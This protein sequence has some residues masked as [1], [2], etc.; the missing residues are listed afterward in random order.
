M[1]VSFT[2]T[3]GQN[4]QFGDELIG[5]KAV[6]RGCGSTFVIPP[7][8]PGTSDLP[9]FELIPDGA[10]APPVG[11]P[12]GSHEPA[13]VRAEA[14]PAPVAAK[15]R[16][17]LAARPFERPQENA[18]TYPCPNSECDA[19]MES[20]PEDIG[21]QEK[22]PSC[23]CR[24]IVPE[25]EPPSRKTLVTGLCVGG[26]TLVAAGV[27]LAAVFLGPHRGEGPAPST[28]GTRAIPV[29][30][31]TASSST[32]SDPRVPKATK[33]PAPTVAN[34]PPKSAP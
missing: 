24:F 34:P 14:G 18:F 15:R 23:R 22:C 9:V 1:P 6:C 25:P 11:A 7:P 13:A 31:R 16:R 12:R 20:T 10:G 8:P 21:K 33:P 2:C 19:I 29:A 28:G 4:H 5:R 27:V 26:A 32:A 3:C 30:A 17:A